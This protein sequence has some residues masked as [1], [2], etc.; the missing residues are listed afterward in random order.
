MKFKINHFPTRL[1]T[2]L[3]RSSASPTKPTVSFGLASTENPPPAAAS[4]EHANVQKTA[5]SRLDRLMK[6]IVQLGGDGIAPLQ[7]ASSDFARCIEIFEY[8]ETA[9][10]MKGSEVNSMHCSINFIRA[11]DQEILFITRRLGHSMIGRLVEHLKE[12]EEIV[13]SQNRVRRLLEQLELNANVN[14]WK[15]VDEIATVGGKLFVDIQRENRLKNLPITPQ[16]KHRSAE[17][18]SLRRVGCTPNTRVEVLKDLR[19]WS[20]TELSEKI[21]WLNGMAGTGKTTIAYS[22]CEELRIAQ[23][24]AASFFCTR[25]LPSCRNVNRI[26]PTISYQLAL[27]SRP[28]RYAVSLA[29]QDLDVHNQPLSEQFECLI[30]KPLSRIQ[31]TLPTD[32]IVVLDALDECED[33]PSVGVLLDVLFSY[34]QRLPVRFFVA[35]RPDTKILDRMRNQAAGQ[36]PKELRLHELDHSVVQGDIK[37]YLENM[38]QPRMKISQVQLEILAER[39]GVLFIYA[40]T[41]VRYIESGNF[42][43]SAKRLK[44]LL[45]AYQTGASSV[46]CEK[47]IDALYTIILERAIND[48]ELNDTDRE[49]M[50]MVLHTIVC[51]QELLSV[52]ILAGLL[53]LDV[54]KSI[55]PA[56]RPLL[57]VLLEWDKTGV[58]SMLHQSFPDYLLGKRRSGQFHCDVGEHHTRIARLCFD[59]ISSISPAF[60]I[61]NLESS[62]AL[63]NEIVDLDDRV[64]KS[65]SREMFY[66]CRYWGA[67][68]MVAKD[69]NGFDTLLFDFLSERLLFWME[70]MNL[71]N[72]IQEGTD[73]LFVVREWY[74]LEEQASGEI[75]QLLQD[76]CEFVRSFASSQAQLSTPHIYVS[77]LSFWPEQRPVSKHYKLKKPQLV[78][79]RKKAISAR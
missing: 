1:I 54:E 46:N 28:F 49:E 30:A 21:Y 58:V 53:R 7:S 67:H 33:S 9:K 35:S 56:L 75:G 23:K 60:N 50:K 45:D 3:N 27:F 55:L 6:L 71:K 34:A 15:T 31:D 8:P 12:T 57:S 42:E 41:V 65:I 14:I 2:L 32:L 39:S 26:V 59:K 70:V 36:L 16:A 72:Y 63:D 5:W 19:D 24:L 79:K 77:H 40:A 76:A 69:S 22:F 29:L 25:Q 20:R 74:Y 11:I 43:R 17:S 37:L 10:D 68:L 48:P 18:V 73:M 47:E 38:L 61:C 78:L 62:F 4:T 13:E 64:Q 66:A 51:A 52:D 44:E